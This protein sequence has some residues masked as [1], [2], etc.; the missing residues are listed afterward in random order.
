[1][2]QVRTGNSNSG[3]FFVFVDSSSRRWRRPSA[4]RGCCELSQK[5]SPGFLVSS[6]FHQ[7]P[8]L[9]F[10]GSKTAGQICGATR[11][12]VPQVPL[13][14]FPRSRAVLALHS[15]RHRS[16]TRPR[17]IGR[18]KRDIRSPSVRRVRSYVC[19]DI[20]AS[21]SFVRPNYVECRAASIKR[22]D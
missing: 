5:R 6:A 3:A 4:D 16:H 17:R 18:P 19:L 2:P 8:P 13:P 20:R 11:G 1:M 10:F 7:T 12:T 9:L 21:R 22:R 14:R 15:R